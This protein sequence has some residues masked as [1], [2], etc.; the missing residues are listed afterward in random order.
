MNGLENFFFS[1]GSYSSSVLIGLH[2]LGDLGDFVW[3]FIRFFCLRYLESHNLYL[4]AEFSSFAISYL[5]V[6]I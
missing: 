6:M 1:L 2:C 4:N 5:D 3:S